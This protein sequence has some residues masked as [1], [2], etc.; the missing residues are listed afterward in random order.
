MK[1]VAHML[2]TSVFSVTVPLQFPLPVPHAASHV[3]GALRNY[4]DAGDN[5]DVGDDDSDDVGDSDDVDDND[6]VGDNG[7]N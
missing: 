4:E 3:E 7:E 2:E 1:E 6:D 5:D